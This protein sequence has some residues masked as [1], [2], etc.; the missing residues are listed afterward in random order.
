[1]RVTYH[2]TVL[3]LEEVREAP[4]YRLL[5]AEQ[6]GVTVRVTDVEL[7]QGPEAYR[8]QRIATLQGREEGLPEPYGRDGSGQEGSPL[9][10]E[11]T[12]DRVYCTGTVDAGGRPVP[13]DDPAAVHRYGVSWWFLGE[14]RAIEVELVLP[15]TKEDAGAELAS[16]TVEDGPVST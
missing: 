15:M 1:M 11:R 4:G 6:G 12:G 7:V 16:V 5:R 8:D 3:D 2:D 10:V 14:D 13:A 9:T